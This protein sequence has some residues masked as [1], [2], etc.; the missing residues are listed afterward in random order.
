MGEEE[1]CGDRNHVKMSQ[2]HIKMI[3]HE[4]PVLVVVTMDFFATNVLVA[5][6]GTNRLLK[7]NGHLTSMTTSITFHA[8]RRK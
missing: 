4:M 3:V 1:A 6:A 7:T 8:E 2:Q 5:T